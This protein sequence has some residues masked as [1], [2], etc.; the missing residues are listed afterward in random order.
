M[1]Q[2]TSA[3]GLGKQRESDVLIFSDLLRIT[4]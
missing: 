1:F 3:M 2:V 4:P